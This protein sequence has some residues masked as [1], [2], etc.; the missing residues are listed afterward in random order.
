MEKFR[1][2]SLGLRLDQSQTATPALLIRTY[3]KSLLIHYYL[4]YFFI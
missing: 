2:G 1:A 4:L 3:P